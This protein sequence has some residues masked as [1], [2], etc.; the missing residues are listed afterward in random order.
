VRNVP[1]AKA[2]PGSTP[3]NLRLQASALA[4]L[5]IEGVLLG[6]GDNPFAGYL[7]LEAPDRAFNTF[8]IVYLYL[9]HSKTS[10]PFSKRGAYTTGIGGVNLSERSYDPFGIKVQVDRFHYRGVSHKKLETFRASPGGWAVHRSFIGGA[11]TCLIHTQSINYT[12]LMMIERIL[13]NARESI[14]TKKA[15]FDAHAETVARA[16]A[17][18]ISSIRA[19]GKVLIFGN[20]GSAADA[21]HIAAELVN[22]L[23][24]DRPP[25][26]AIALTTDTS[27]LTSVGNDSSF[28]DLF[29]RQLRALGRSGDV[30]LAIST[31]GSSPNVLRAVEVARE[32]GIKTVGLAGRDGGKLASMVDIALVVETSSTQRIQ[33]T[34]I[35]IGHILCELIED[36]LFGTVNETGADGG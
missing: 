34:H 31:S 3:R 2:L 20:G 36:E 19:G 33:E 17:L 14:E 1:L 28:D 8:V 24:Y 30:A 13:Q 9:C 32:L 35:T 11:T 26:A 12:A 6:V 15:F 23:N 18:V 10:D 7:S 21:Q 22:R 16:A 29:A 4:G 5:Q 27:I 25:I